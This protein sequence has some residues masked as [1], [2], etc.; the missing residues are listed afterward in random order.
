MTWNEV[1]CSVCGERVPDAQ[2]GEHT[3]LKHPEIVLA[4]RRRDKDETKPFLQIVIP[5]FAVWL[6]AFLLL[7]ALPGAPPLALTIPGMLFILLGIVVAGYRYALRVTVS[8][9]ENVRLK[10]RVCDAFVPEPDYFAHYREVHPGYA[11]YIVFARAITWGSI[12]IVF[13]VN[14][15]VFLVASRSPGLDILAI[16]TIST[17]SGLFVWLGFVSLWWFGVDPSFLARVRSEWRD[18][19]SSLRR[20]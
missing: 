3:A 10:C 7:L 2:L 11:R 16:T 9:V 1:E 4:E 5:S 14:L 19:H 13:L 17:Y 15:I 8:D 18:S 6:V 20:P 12:V